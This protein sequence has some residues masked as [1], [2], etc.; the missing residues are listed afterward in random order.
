MH[1]Y[2]CCRIAIFDS[3]FLTNF[4]YRFPFLLVTNIFMLVNL[5][6]LSISGYLFYFL[7]ILSLFPWGKV[8]KRYCG[9]S[10]TMHIAAAFGRNC[11]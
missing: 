3:Y 4:N 9:V 8:E 6:F 10:E 2:R 7:N 5:I 1:V 11:F